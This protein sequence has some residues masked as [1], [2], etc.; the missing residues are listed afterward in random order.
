MRASHQKGIL[1]MLAMRLRIRPVARLRSVVKRYY[2]LTQITLVVAAFQ[3]Y[4]AFRRMIDPNWG[5]A[6][7]NAHRIVS[8]ERITH[9]GWE[10]SLQRA[11]LQI[12]DLVQAMNVF[13]FV[14]H[15]LLTGIFFFWLYHRSCDGF[16]SFRN[17]FLV[18]TAL[19][20]LIHW[21]FP[22]APP[23]LAG[24]GL[25]DTLRQ[26]SHID[27]GSDRT[28][29]YYNPVAAIPSLHAGYALGV[30]I[31]LALYARRHWVRILGALYPAAVV[32]TIVVTGNHFVLDAIAGMAV[33]AAGFLLARTVPGR[34]LKGGGGGAILASAT[35]GGAVR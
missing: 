34:R 9:L 3:V 26:L 8:V 25:Q 35:R 29:S 28:S 6:M 7:A 11:F 22:T 23:R 33:L 14:G 17:A 27:I 10:Q 5:A 19:A 21:K 2:G 24:V 1:A 4:E 20:L 16:R 32:L 12:P 18:T 30:G 31:G 13:Y 15:F